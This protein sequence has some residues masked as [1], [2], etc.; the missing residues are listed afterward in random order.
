MDSPWKELEAC[1][2]WSRGWQQETSEDKPRKAAQSHF[3]LRIYNRLWT[4]APVKIPEHECNIIVSSALPIEPCFLSPF[5]SKPLS[6]ALPSSMS[7]QSQPWDWSSLATNVLL[8]LPFSLC[9]VNKDQPGTILAHLSEPMSLSTKAVSS[10]DMSLHP[11]GP[12]LG[13]H[14]SLWK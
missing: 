3:C 14:L 11:K 2:D 1:L 10:V 9:R 4:E 7:P 6:K 13:L 5:S 12:R 8:S